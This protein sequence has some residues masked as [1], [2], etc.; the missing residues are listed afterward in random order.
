MATEG[1]APTFTAGGISSA[2]NLTMELINRLIND[3][4][5]EVT[6]K[7]K[8]IEGQL[9][10][11]RNIVEEYKIQTIDPTIKFKTTLEVV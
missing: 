8:E 7:I 2:T 9:N 1:S 10:G 3:Q 6:R 4:L 11:S 5:G